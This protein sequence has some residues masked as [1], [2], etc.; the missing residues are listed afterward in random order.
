[1]PF[2]MVLASFPLARHDG[3]NEVS[4]APYVLS[5]YVTENWG[6][7]NPPIILALDILLSLF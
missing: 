7:N 5:S 3:L 4:C 6:N 2:S 1:M